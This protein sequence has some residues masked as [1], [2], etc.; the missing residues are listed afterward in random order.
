MGHR[1]LVVCTANV[2]RSPMVAAMLGHRLDP[3]LF[4]ID[5]AGVRAP[6]GRPMDPDSADQLRARGVPVPQRTAQQL[7]RDLVLGADLALTATRAH[8][9]D[10]LDLDPRALRRTFTV[11]EFAALAQLA[12]TGGVDDIV[13]AAAGLRTQG[14]ADTDL[15]DPIGRPPAVHAEVAE[16]AGGAVTAIV[17][18]FGG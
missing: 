9:A 14:P 5:S 15:Q 8:R 6:R 3:Q 2:C 7:T 12:E 10:V 13:R 1:I 4:T 17:A 16:R 18:A 11:L